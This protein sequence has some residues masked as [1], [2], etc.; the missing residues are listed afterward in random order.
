L[1][2]SDDSN[3]FEAAALLESDKE[4]DDYYNASVRTTKAN[5]VSLDV[6]WDKFHVGAL[7]SGI[8]FTGS[9]T[10]L[11]FLEAERESPAMIWAPKIE[12]DSLQQTDSVLT[13]D[14]LVEPGGEDDYWQI[15]I[16]RVPSSISAL[17]S[18]VKVTNLVHQ[19]PKGF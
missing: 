12:I 5:L 13:V 19:T 14:W 7:H 10:M 16:L 17:R 4:W 15:K 1:R 2:Y 18:I 11:Q 3:R 6:D 8:A 9:K